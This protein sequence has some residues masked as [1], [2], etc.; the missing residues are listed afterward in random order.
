MERLNINDRKL[1]LNFWF[2]PCCKGDT[3]NKLIEKGK[4]DKDEDCFLKDK[5]FKLIDV[6]QIWFSSFINIGSSAYYCTLEFGIVL[7]IDSN[8]KQP[9]VSI[10]WQIQPDKHEVTYPKKEHK[11]LH[12]KKDSAWKL[13][14]K[15]EFV[16]ILENGFRKAKKDYEKEYAGTKLTEE[17]RIPYLRK[18]LK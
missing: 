15:E 6:G 13:P 17:K 3:I 11:L 2:S 8:V 12:S 16:E 7:E 9:D 1:S 14:P 18:V 5:K 4:F 10:Y